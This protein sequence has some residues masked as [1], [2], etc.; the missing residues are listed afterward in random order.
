ML[1]EFNF[2]YKDKSESLKLTWLHKKHK[3]LYAK[4]YLKTYKSVY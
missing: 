3:Y 4:I 2:I 1:A